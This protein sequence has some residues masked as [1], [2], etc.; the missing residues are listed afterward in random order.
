MADA[1]KTDTETKKVFFITS[2]QSKLD[3]YI[4]YEIPRNRG[5][6]NLKAGDSNNE[7]CEQRNYKR[8]Q[9]T[10]YINSMEISPKD[11]KKDDQDPT[12]K[13]YKTVLS[14]KHNRCTFPADIIFRNGKNNFIY[15][16]QF[17][18]HKG[19]YKNYDPPPQIKLS[20]SEQL[21]IYINYIVKVLNKKYSNKRWR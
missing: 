6:I 12:S 9:F 13:K 20:E 14:L 16:L 21:K 10:L 5:L 15:D 3:K 7:M 19:L 11:L 17:N 4:K 8:E 2:N 1:N 18:E